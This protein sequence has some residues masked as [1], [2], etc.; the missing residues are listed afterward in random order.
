[1]EA[2]WPQLGA[3]DADLV[4][5]FQEAGMAFRHPKAKLEILLRD[6]RNGIAGQHDGTD[7]HQ[8]FQD[9]P[10]GRGKHLPLIELLLDDGALG[11]PRP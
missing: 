1:M 10:A 9:A 7:R 6:H 2:C 3:V 5:G 11:G 8:L 4:A